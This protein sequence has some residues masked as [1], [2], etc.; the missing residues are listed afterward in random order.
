MELLSLNAASR[1]LREKRKLLIYGKCVEVERPGLIEKLSE[2]RVAVWACP[3]RD[4]INVIALKVASILARVDLEE[5][6]VVTVDGSPHCVQLH[7]AV[8][9]AIKVA[10]SELSARHLVCH[11]DEIIEV[12]PRAVK[13][14][15]YLSKVERLLR[16]EGERRN[17]P[18]REQ[19]MR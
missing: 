10:K 1:L 18:E 14:A 3:E 16:L 11:G 17:S 8:E 15:R 19:K 4:H 6:A 7:H 5:M 2:G 13:A 12:S 9:E